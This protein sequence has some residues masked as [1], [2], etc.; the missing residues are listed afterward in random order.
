[1]APP[2]GL[3]AGS[4]VHHGQEGLLQ[5]VGDGTSGC[6]EE[7]CIHVLKRL[8][9]DTTLMRQMLRALTVDA[10]PSGDVAGLVVGEEEAGNR[11]TCSH[12][13]VREGDGRLQLDQG[14]VIAGK[15]T[16]TH[17]HTHFHTDSS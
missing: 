7:R 12:D 1:M 17:T 15:E 11:E 8:V 10:T 16:N 3:G 14:D 5:D 13:G 9:R 2:V 6:V 4:V